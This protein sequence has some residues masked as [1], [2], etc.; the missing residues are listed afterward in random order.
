MHSSENTTRIALTI[1]ALT[2]S[3]G[4]TLAQDVTK[5]PNL[6]V[7]GT[8]ANDINDQGEIV[9]QAAR[10]GGL[11]VAAVRWDASHT[12]T[13][14]VSLRDWHDDRSARDQQQRRDRGL[15]RR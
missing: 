4:T 3:S 12:P 9:G 2:L 5:L 10:T 6:G 8:M 15:F 7:S 13:A 1:L 11:G 14:L